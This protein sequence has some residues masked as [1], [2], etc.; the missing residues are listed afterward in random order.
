MVEMKGERYARALIEASID[1][2]VTISPEGK[3]TDVNEATVKATG[4]PR[5]KLIGTNFSDYFTE[6]EKA[7]AGYKQALKEGI[8]TDYPLSIK[9]VSGKLM[10]VLYNASVLKDEEGKVLGVFASARDITS[11]IKA[12]FLEGAEELLSEWA[13]SLSRLAFS[14]R[15]GLNTFKEIE[16][17]AATHWLKRTVGE[18]PVA[19]TAYE[20]AVRF[21][22]LSN[23][24]KVTKKENFKLEEKG[25]TILGTFLSQDCSYKNSCIALKKEGK[26]YLCLRAT[27][28]VIAIDLMADK[29]YKAEVLYEQTQPGTVCIIRGLP[30]E[31]TFKVGLS[32]KLSKGTVKIHELDCEK[33]GIGI[34]DTIT[35]NPT[36]KVISDR[37][38]VAMSYS[39]TKYPPGMILMNVG[40]AKSLGLEEKDTIFIRKAGKGEEAKLVEVEEY[41]A[42]PGAYEGAYETPGL[43]SPE[44]KPKK[45]VEEKPREEKKEEK[46]EEQKPKEELKEKP[47]EEKFEEKPKEKPKP[48]PQKE[49]KFKPKEEPDFKKKQKMEEF[50]ARIEAIRNA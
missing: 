49:K 25:E 48:D 41:E 18:L 11:R 5:E 4:I 44:E 34:I 20:A 35:I 6:P 42:K 37:K 22:D 12:E 45:K 36:R 46:K 13:Y 30:T 50:E 43:E 40:D 7:N 24:R 19:K 27:P 15:E 21:R 39:Q 8:L 3:I 17:D 10:H 33:V 47:K 28:F 9:H 2:L 23:E 16:R 26:N 31:L 1:P 32:Y 29:H 14:S 38:L